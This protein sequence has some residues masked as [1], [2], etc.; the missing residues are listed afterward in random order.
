MTWQELQRLAITSLKDPADAARTL[1]A[2][3]LP[4][5][6]LWDL[7]VL[8]AIGNTILFYFSNLFFP[9]PSPLLAMFTAP[10]VYFLVVSGGLALMA[11]S[12][13]WTGRFM[14]GKG[15]LADILVLIVWMQMLRLLVQAVVLVLMFVMPVLSA[16]LVLAVA[17]VGI[18][19]LLHFIN[20]AHRYGSLGRSAVV[21]ILSFLAIVVGL[22]ILLTLIGGP[23]VG[24][25]LNV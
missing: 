25:T 4:T 17:L 18:Y 19:V 9:G 6:V 1:L 13:C 12:I 16:L 14:G 23:F 3:Q 10:F 20:Q 21:L 7:L 2:M 5:R 11:V 24:S 8:V 15:T 22:S